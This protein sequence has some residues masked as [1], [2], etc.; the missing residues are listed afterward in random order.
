[1]TPPTVAVPP[2]S[3]HRVCS[4]HRAPTPRGHHHSSLKKIYIW[5]ASPA[6]TTACIVF[7]RLKAKR[8]W[9]TMLMKRHQQCGTK[10]KQTN[11]KTKPVRHFQ[12]DHIHNPVKLFG[13]LSLVTCFN[14]GNFTT[15]NA[16]NILSEIP[17]SLTK[18]SHGLKKT[19]KNKSWFMKPWEPQINHV[20]V[21]SHNNIQRSIKIKKMMQPCWDKQ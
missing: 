12:V 18:V 4:L 9:I 15:T 14:V 2:L 16:S 8:S 17:C 10:K 6:P 11:I 3:I 13:G 7:L 21:T 20:F 5:H 1:M 19:K